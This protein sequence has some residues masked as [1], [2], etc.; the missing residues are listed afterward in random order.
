MT[1][2]RTPKEI[3]EKIC[4]EG[5]QHVY[6]VCKDIEQAIAAERDLA[7]NEYAIVCHWKEKVEKLEFENER[8]RTAL[9]QL[10]KESGSE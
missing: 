9:N 10:Q 3:A 8:M 1:D 2:K 7:G 5:T 4:G 6:C